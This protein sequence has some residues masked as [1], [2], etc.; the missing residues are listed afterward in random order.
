MSNRQFISDLRKNDP[1]S[2]IYDGIHQNHFPPAFAKTNHMN[3][4]HHTG[5]TLLATVLLFLSAVPPAEAQDSIGMDQLIGAEKMVDLQFTPAKRDSIISGLVSNLHLYQYMHR[6]DLPNAVP[7]SLSFD[8]TLPGMHF[9][10]RQRP[11]EWNIPSD[12]ELPADQAGLAFYSI[13]QLASLIKN[14]KITSLELTR[15]FIARLKK[16]GPILH[17]VIELTEDSALTQARRADTDLAAG[18]YKSPLQGIPYGIKD[19]FSVKGSHTTWGSP[20]YKD[21]SF[22]VT[23]FVA[24]ELQKAGAILVAKLSLEYPDRVG[25]IFSRFGRRYLGRSGTLCHRHGDLWLDRG[26]FDALRR[27]GFAA[28]IRERGENRMHGA[29]LELG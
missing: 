9:E 1:F 7:M 14:K 28:H 20:P 22:P 18:I 11:L 2:L 24:T 23:S 5:I 29:L 17:C 15:Y 13:P 27:N 8:P 25:R 3:K 4:Q 6:Q 16:Y 19:L 21:Q 10:R 12:V 26:S